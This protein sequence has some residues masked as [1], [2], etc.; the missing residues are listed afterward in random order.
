MLKYVQSVSK[1][2]SLK[3]TNKVFRLECQYVHVKIILS[4][5]QKIVYFETF[6]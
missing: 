2:P 4:I 1:A 5:K 3:H 6:N